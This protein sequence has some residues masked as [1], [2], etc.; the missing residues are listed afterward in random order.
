MNVCYKFKSVPVCDGIKALVDYIKK[1]YSELMSMQIFTLRNFYATAQQISV[2]I[3]TLT[4][5]ELYNGLIGYK[6]ER[7]LFAIIVL[8]KMGECFELYDMDISFNANLK[9]ILEIEDKIIFNKDELF[10]HLD[11][12]YKTEKLLPQLEKGIELFLT[13]YRKEVLGNQ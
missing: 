6:D 1:S 13:I 11:T 9:T 3:T 5:D 4:G 7:T 10:S 12:E 2:D 8:A